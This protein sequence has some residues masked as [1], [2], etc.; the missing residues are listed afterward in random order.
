LILIPPCCSDVFYSRHYTR[1]TSQWT[2]LQGSPAV[3][4]SRSGLASSEVTPGARA[5]AGSA[6]D[7]N[8]NLLLWGG[9]GGGTTYF[10]DVFSFSPSSLLWT[11]MAGSISANQAPVYASDIPQHIAVPGDSIA[12]GARLA[13]TVWWTGNKLLLFAGANSLSQAT[14]DLCVTL[15]CVLL[16]EIQAKRRSDEFSCVLRCLTCRW[17][18]STINGTFA[19]WHGSKQPLAVNAITESYCQTSLSGDVA[20]KGMHMCSCR[21]LAQ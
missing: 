21:T 13:P 14:N 19:W 11:Y 3:G 18:Y 16:V 2:W 6:V 10:G 15:A 17:S 20:I 4:V 7:S 1:H 12:A 9:Y 5:F 8:G